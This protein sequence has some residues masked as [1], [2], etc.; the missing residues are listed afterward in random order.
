MHLVTAPLASSDA[1]L[2]EVLIRADR[3]TLAKRLWRAAAE[4]GTEFG[5]QLEAP[6]EDGAVV[7]AA[8]NAHYVIRQ[9]EEPVLEITL[10]GPPES[11]A[12]LGWSIGNLHATIEPRPGKLLTPDD[13]AMRQALT[14]MG[15]VFAPTTAIFHPPRQAHSHDHDHA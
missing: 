15:V 1:S 6:L 2:P 8:A 12:L 9:T 14:R 7:W 10:A 5:F 4:D 3:R 11:L 13:P